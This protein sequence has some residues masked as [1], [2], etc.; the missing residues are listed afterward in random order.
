MARRVSGKGTVSIKRVH[1]ER[2]IGIDVDSE[3]LVTAFLN[4]ASKEPTGRRLTPS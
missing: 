4:A 3:Y 1:L 2:T